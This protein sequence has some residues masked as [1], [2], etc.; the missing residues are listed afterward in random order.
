MEPSVCADSQSRC[1]SHL[2]SYFLSDPK[3]S[4][5]YFILNIY[6]RTQF[7]SI[8][9]ANSLPLFLLCQ[10]LTSESHW[11]AS[12]S[13]CHL[14]E[15]PLHFLYYSSS[16]LHSSNW[17][18]ACCPTEVNSVLSN[19]QHQG[20]YL[21]SAPWRAYG[22]ILEIAECGLSSTLLLLQTGKWNVH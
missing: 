21:F 19:F 16:D 2:L 8:L 1:V 5:F 18:S 6:G 10:T 11:V 15:Q 22:L 12:C 20:W 13:N 4:I 7:A 14:N 3:F 17:S 9:D